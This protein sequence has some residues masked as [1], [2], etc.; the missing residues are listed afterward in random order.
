VGVSETR[1]CKLDLNCDKDSFPD[2]HHSLEKTVRDYYCLI[3]YGKG[4]WLM[5]R[6][7]MSSATSSLVLQFLANSAL[8]RKHFRG[9]LGSGE[10]YEDSYRLR[11]GQG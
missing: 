4:V 5:V 10:H 8:P 7:Q 11:H 6:N 2:A 9:S 3:K 1:F